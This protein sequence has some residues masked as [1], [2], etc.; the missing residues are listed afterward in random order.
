MR[1][2]RPLSFSV[3]YLCRLRLSSE[4]F[5]S[6]AA[7]GEQRRPFS[8][9]TVWCAA[10]QKY[11]DLV[12]QKAHWWEGCLQCS[13]TS[14]SSHNDWCRWELVCCLHNGTAGSFRTDLKN[15]LQVFKI[16][17]PEYQAHSLRRSGASWYCQVCKSIDVVMVWGRWTHRNTARIYF[18]SAAEAFYNSSLSDRSNKRL[19]E[20][21]ACFERI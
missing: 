9:S 2:H 12:T 4:N 13:D 16:I 18:E 5:G 8:H 1:F 11:E 20:L 21:S 6:C 15:L 17:D 10:A 19:R 3:V 7:K 14:A